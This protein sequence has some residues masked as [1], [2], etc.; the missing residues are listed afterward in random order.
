MALQA[1]ADYRGNF[2]KVMIES[3]PFFVLFFFS[4]VHFYFFSLPKWKDKLRNS[5]VGFPDSR[6]PTSSV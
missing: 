6:T 2:R 4:I 3:I 1:L 5:P